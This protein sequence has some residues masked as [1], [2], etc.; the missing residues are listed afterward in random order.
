M[1]EVVASPVASARTSLRAFITRAQGLTPDGQGIRWNPSR[2]RFEAIQWSLE[3]RF[4]D[5]LPPQATVIGD[6]T[7]DQTLFTA[8]WVAARDSGC[9]VLE[10]RTFKAPPGQDIWFCTLEVQAEDAGKVQPVLSMWESRDI[11]DGLFYMVAER[12]LEEVSQPLRRWMDLACSL[13]R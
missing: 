11:D 2:N 9:Q 13:G 6:L 10:N 12:A 8:L 7:R 4:S 1:K 5:T 3:Q